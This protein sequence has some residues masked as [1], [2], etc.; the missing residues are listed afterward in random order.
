MQSHSIKYFDQW[1]DQARSQL[2]AGIDPAQIDFQDAWQP[3]SLI[4]FGDRSGEP[5]C[6]RAD[7]A[8]RSR[9]VFTVPKPFLR[10][11]R[12]VAC[13]RD[14][15][16]WNLLYRILWRLTHGEPELL[17]MVTDDDVYLAR[18]W[19]KQV[20]RDAHKMKAFVRFR[21]CDRDG[22]EWFVAWY[23]PDHRIVR[24]V[25]PFFADRFSSMRWSI[26]TPEESVS[27]DLRQLR[28]GPG[29]GREAAPQ[30]DELEEMWLSY[31]SST[32]NPARLKL[33][34]MRAEMPVRYWTTL[35]ETAVIDQLIDQA[36]Q[37]V[38]EMVRHRENAVLTA[39]DFLPNHPD[40]PSLR[41][42]ARKCA[43]CPLH[44]D[45]TQT[46]FGEGPA[47]AKLVL[48]GEQPGDEEDRAGKPFVGPAGRL[49]DEILRAA[50]IDREKVY[51]TNAV[52]HFSH[53]QHGKRRLHKK[54][55]Q[56]EV[57]ACRAWLE[58]ELRIIRPQA[59]VCLGATAAG[60]LITPSFRVTDE[61]GRVIQTKWCSQ[62][63]ATL[64]PSAILRA[65]DEND[66]ATKRAAM[67]ADLRMA[68]SL[69]PT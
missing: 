57:V 55:R 43:G 33:K 7:S 5:S 46:V 9:A 12:S 39:M 36:P 29:T 18:A 58:S 23:R 13:H 11:A 40:L 61:R 67:I 25:T 68:R 56:I 15:R 51:L 66:A 64:H 44:A 63:I 35:P 38:A 34:A 53:V 41:A 50:E 19:Q 42:A 54:P 2:R 27:W 8:H 14:G 65:R 60:S 49:L 31:Y 6:F 52:K 4:D 16:R 22:D 69:L 62:T 17:E 30:G 48:V 37:R 32:F 10:L 3:Q 26:F 59:V 47:D 1:R 21:C 20:G 28:F 24:S 45:T